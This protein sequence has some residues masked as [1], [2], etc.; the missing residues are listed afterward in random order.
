MKKTGIS[1][2]KI[3]LIGEHSVVYGE[4]AIAIP[5]L[6]TAIETVIE[7][8]T[9][10]VIL[11]CF[12]YKG[13]L[14]QAPKRLL[15]L[16]TVI[17]ETV[18]TLAKPLENFTITIS[19]TIPAERGMGSSAAV[20]VATIRALF[21]YF[22]EPLS[23]TVLLELTNISETIA[24]GNPS[25]LDAAMTSS[26]SPLYYVK[27]QE[28]EFF[29]LNMTAYLV[30]A[31][32]GI[33]GQ[34][35]EAVEHIAQLYQ[36][37][38]KQTGYLIKQLGQLAKKTKL[39]IEKNQAITLGTNMTQ[40]HKLLSSLGVSNRELDCLVDTALDS[41][42]L[43]AKLTGGGRGGCMIALAKNETAAK[44]LATDLLEA[45]AQHTWLYNM[46]KDGYDD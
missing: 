36:S 27:G 39:A 33:T 19:S 34:T 20:A 25:G 21:R 2:G 11:D 3:I 6:A 43:G 7:T 16:A 29:P 32:T 22:D 23:N 38:P 42:A 35:K 13:P 37:A 26:N 1:N 10:P 45:G 41:G 15:N 4:P 24:H 9:G 12:F 14:S 46:R 30:V 5:F 18:K 31:D 8:T 17:K 40:A 44:R 28:F